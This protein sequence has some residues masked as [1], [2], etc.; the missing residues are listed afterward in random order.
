LFQRR[1]ASAAMDEDHLLAAVRYLV[2]NP[3]KAR[4]AAAPK[5]LALVERAPTQAAR[6]MP[7][8][9]SRRR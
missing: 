5:P 9:A 8:L 7:W 6:T 2:F 3:V 4:L 1:F